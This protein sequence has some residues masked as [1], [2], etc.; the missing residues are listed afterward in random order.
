MSLPPGWKETDAR[1]LAVPDR[2][3]DMIARQSC[4][5]WRLRRRLESEEAELARMCQAAP[6]YLH[7]EE[8]EG[9]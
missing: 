7:R 4:K 3:G 6:P 1:R 8:V 5:V 2:Y 9:E